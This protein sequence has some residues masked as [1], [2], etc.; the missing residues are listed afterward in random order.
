MKFLQGE[1]KQ[2]AGTLHNTIDI[3]TLISDKERLEKD[4][5]NKSIYTR[6]FT[7]IGIGIALCLI[8]ITIYNYRKKKEFLKNYNDLLNNVNLYLLKKVQ[9]KAIL[10]FQ[11]L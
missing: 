6:Y 10:L 2:L 1:Y 9:M 8:F 7:I 11:I 5:N 3:K 4:L